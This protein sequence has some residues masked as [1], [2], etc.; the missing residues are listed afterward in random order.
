MLFSPFKPRLGPVALRDSRRTKSVY[1]SQLYDHTDTRTRP[2]STGG[3]LG[4]RKWMS[5]K[6]ALPL[7]RDVS[8]KAPTQADEEKPIPGPA[9]LTSE[10]LGSRHLQP[11]VSTALAAEYEE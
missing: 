9:A 5:G 3:S 4:V 1:F 7:A 2:A 11:S 10:A 8:A 6:K